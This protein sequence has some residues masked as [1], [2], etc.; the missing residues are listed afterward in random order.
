MT[1]LKIENLSPALQEKISP[2]FHEILQKSGPRVH[3]LYLVGSVL[4]EDYLEKV[5]DIN[6]IIMLQQMDLSFLDLLAPLGKKHGPQGLAV[7]LIMDLDYLRSSVDVFPSEFLNFK[8]VHQTIYGEDLLAGVEIDLKELRLQC[9]RELRGKLIW[10]QRIYLSALGDNQVLAGD[11]IRHFR[12]YLPLMRGILYL[13]GQAP[14][15]GLKACLD[16]LAD[17]TGAATGVFAEVFALKRQSAKPA[18]E[19]MAHL[20]VR[21]YEAAEKLAEVVDGLQI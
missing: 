9:E 16:R 5:S 13:L 7:P 3:S 20:F 12:G 17:L 21:F 15:T 11:I 6:S 8:L 10:L 18:R 14:P 4:T 2:F 1:C 19:E